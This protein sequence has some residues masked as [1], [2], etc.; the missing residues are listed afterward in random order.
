MPL[1]ITPA[2]PQV[3]CFAQNYILSAKFCLQTNICW[4]Y[5]WMNV[6]C[7]FSATA[8][9]LVLNKPSTQIS[10]ADTHPTSSSSTTQDPYYNL[11][12]P[13]PAFAIQVQAQHKSSP[14]PIPQSRYFLQPRFFLILACSPL[15]CWPSLSQLC[16]SVHPAFKASQIRILC[17]SF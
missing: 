9:A 17:G 8:W 7:A 12:L 14:G 2:S 1:Y 16:I 15:L 3:L 4:M 13:T 6:S 11:P 10:N 5:E